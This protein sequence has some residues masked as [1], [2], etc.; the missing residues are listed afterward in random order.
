MPQDFFGLAWIGRTEMVSISMNVILTYFKFLK[1]IL[2]IQELQ[3]NPD[4]GFCILFNKVH[5]I[6]YLVCFS[7]TCVDKF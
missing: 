2:Q 6:Q 3:L 5:E 1:P 4:D 7:K